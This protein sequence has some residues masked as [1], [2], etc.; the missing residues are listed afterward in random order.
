MQPYICLHPRSGSQMRGLLA[1]LSVFAAAGCPPG[2]Y[3]D[4]GVCAPCQPGYYKPDSSNSSAC[5]PCPVGTVC[6][7]AGSSMPIVLGVGQNGSVGQCVIG[8]CVNAIRSADNSCTTCLPGF[9]LRG[10]ACE[11]CAPG[12]YSGHYGSVEC[13]VCPNGTYAQFN[14]SVGCAAC[15]AGKYASSP[16]AT[17]CSTC[18]FRETNSPNFDACVCVA[19][20]SDSSGACLPCSPGHYWAEGM[21]IPCPP[22]TGLSD[23]IADTCVPCAPGFYSNS[24]LPGICVLCPLST[25]SSGS[26]R[27][28]CTSCPVGALLLLV[29]YHNNTR[30]VCTIYVVFC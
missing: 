12:R 22:G 18:G 25:Y 28:A 14:A 6:A 19:G 9:F 26:G 4:Q 17:R 10:G 24:S 27:S 15:D 20:S 3:W 21:C 8:S 7:S 11:P 30:R 29:S 23:V 1:L 5:W 2:L 16:G 13:D